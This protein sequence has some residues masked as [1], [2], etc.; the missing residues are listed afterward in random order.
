M[1]FVH[2]VVR[3]SFI[4]W[5]V[6]IKINTLFFFSYSGIY[7]KTFAANTICRENIAVVVSMPN[8]CG[9]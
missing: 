6:R 4:K 3:D 5:T 9:L 1:D 2:T 7:L 8:D